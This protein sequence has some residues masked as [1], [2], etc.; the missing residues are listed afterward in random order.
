M[1]V[2]TQRRVVTGEEVAE[3]ATPDLHLEDLRFRSLEP[4]VP[5]QG[6]ELLEGRQHHGRDRQRPLRRLID[7]KVAVRVGQLLSPSSNRH[8]QLVLALGWVR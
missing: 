3:E 8:D 5:E 4:H 2:V 1:T 7:Y 6:N